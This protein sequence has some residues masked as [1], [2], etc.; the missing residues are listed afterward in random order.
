MHRGAR[1]LKFGRTIFTTANS[2]T[3]PSKS[4]DD[5]TAIWGD[6]QKFQ[7]PAQSGPAAPNFNQP[8]NQSWGGNN[9]EGKLIFM[10]VTIRYLFSYLCA[11][12]WSDFDI[13]NK[14]TKNITGAHAC[15]LDKH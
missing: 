15:I 10:V 13:P 3:G 7:K 8:R 14:T 1:R 12:V 6:P 11:V 4:V 2:L 5:G 9:N